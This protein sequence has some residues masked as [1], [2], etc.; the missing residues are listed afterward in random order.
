MT[1]DNRRKSP[2]HVD[3][4]V[5]TMVLWDAA[6]TYLQYVG[7][8]IAGGDLL[9]MTEE[10]T[11]R[12][13]SAVAVEVAK[14]VEEGVRRREIDLGVDDAARTQLLSFEIDVLAVSRLARSEVEL[15]ELT[16]GAVILEFTIPDE[17]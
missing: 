10:A 12:F 5:L 6:G 4:Q 7:G 3:V 14:T 1:F 11:S 17:G 2:Q 15:P 9:R 8:Y 16:D 13:W